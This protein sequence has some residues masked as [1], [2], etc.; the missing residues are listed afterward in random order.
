MEDW[1]VEQTDNPI[2]NEKILLSIARQKIWLHWVMWFIPIISIATCILSAVLIRNWRPWAWGFG[3]GFVLGAFGA[4]RDP[5]T[6]LVA[7]V[8][9]A[10]IGAALTHQEIQKARDCIDSY[11]KKDLL[12]G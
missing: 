11:R 7:N 9:S 4:T 3:V 12:D 2:K 1:R 5:S 6:L 10:G 8:F